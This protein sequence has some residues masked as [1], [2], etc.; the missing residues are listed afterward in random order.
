[1]AQLIKWQSPHIRL[2]TLEKAAGVD[3]KTFRGY[4]TNE[5]DER[6][7]IRIPR[8]RWKWYGMEEAMA[9]LGLSHLN[10]IYVDI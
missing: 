8:D 5:L 4:N 6:I 7:S 10:V 3:F 2:S 1:M 9:R